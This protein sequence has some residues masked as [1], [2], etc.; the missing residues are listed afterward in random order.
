[1]KKQDTARWSYKDT[2]VREIEMQVQALFTPTPRER[3]IVVA[4]Q[5]GTRLVRRVIES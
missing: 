4:A 5:G 3:C 1:M 2:R